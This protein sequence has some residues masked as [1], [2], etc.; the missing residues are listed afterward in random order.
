MIGE[1]PWEDYHHRSHLLDDI[2]DYSNE[3]NHPS[4]VDFLSNLDFIDIVYSE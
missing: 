1:E 3:L 2:K 4:L